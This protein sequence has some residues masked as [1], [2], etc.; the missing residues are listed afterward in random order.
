MELKILTVGHACLDVVHQVER[1]PEKDS[2]V[3]SSNVDIRIG[4][5]AAN[6]AAAIADLGCQSHLCTS[7]G[8]EYHPFTRILV[9]L[10]TSKGINISNCEFVDSQACPNSNIMILPTGERT[11]VNW[12]SDFFLNHIVHPKS[13][14]GYSAILAD[15]YRLPMVQSVLKEANRY[16]IPTILDVDNPKQKLKEIP[17]A[18]QI[19]F[20]YEAWQQLGISLFD[21]QLR[22]GADIIGV[23]NG[24]NEIQWIDQTQNLRSY[25]PPSVVPINTLGAGDVFKGRLAIGLSLDEP[26]AISIR[27]ACISAAEHI[28]N[29]P[30]TKLV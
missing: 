25:M 19:W 4:G 10:L 21:L 9:S 12:Q 30:L 20:G 27:E 1:L 26:I 5:N 24:P 11:I 23:T 29:K 7:M 16:G 3:P 28:Q 18:K 8:S 2:K 13:I 6:A 22:T 17:R 14:T 15:T